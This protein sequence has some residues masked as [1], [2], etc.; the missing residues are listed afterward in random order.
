MNIIWLQPRPGKSLE[1]DVREASKSLKS[2]G[3]PCTRSQDHP[4]ILLVLDADWHRAYQLLVADNLICCENVCTRSISA[5]RHV[6][7]ARMKAVD[8]CQTVHT[9]WVALAEQYGVASSRR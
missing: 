8:I 9:N 2:E 3:I 7:L 1:E 4:G 6:E 5:I